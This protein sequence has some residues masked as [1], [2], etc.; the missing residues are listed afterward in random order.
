MF[1]IMTI[2]CRRSL[3]FQ[4]RIMNVS[5]QITAET[6]PSARCCHGKSLL[7][8][9]FWLWILFWGWYF[10]YRT[11]QFWCPLERVNSM[12]D[13][14]SCLTLGTQKSK[15]NTSSVQMCDTRERG[16]VTRW[17]KRIF[18]T[19]MWGTNPAVAE[20]NQTNIARNRSPFISDLPKKDK[21]KLQAGKTTLVLLA[22]LIF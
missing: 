7:H 15:G 18:W 12:A 17:W 4:C 2:S 1:I 3:F 8:R 22:F 20:R 10:L 16:F 21:Y 9:S 14:C 11:L 5:A 6:Q 19:K 13:C